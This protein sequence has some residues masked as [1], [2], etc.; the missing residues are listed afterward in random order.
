MADSLR[1]DPA[2]GI[3]LNVTSDEALLLNLD[4]ET[5]FSLNATGADVVALIFDG[6]DVAS[7][8]T[9]MVERFQADRRDIE[10]D[11]KGLLL[12]LESAGLLVR[13]LASDAD[14]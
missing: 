7:V 1:Y 11:V 10:N 8:V 13:R 2:P 12:E 3:T 5:M 4:A 6:H 9:T 14:E